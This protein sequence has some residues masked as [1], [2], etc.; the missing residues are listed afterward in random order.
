FLFLRA[1]RIS[2]ERDTI[3]FQLFSVSED[4]QSPCG[5]LHQNPIDRC[6]GG[7]RIPDLVRVNPNAAEQQGDR[8][9]RE[10]NSS[11][12][13]ASIRVDDL[14]FFRLSRILRSADRSRTSFGRRKH[15]QSVRRTARICDRASRAR[16][17]PLA[18][19][20]RG[21]PIYQQ[22]SAARCAARF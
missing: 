16:E 6:S 11:K 12:H 7:Q 4:R 3:T 18:H 13:P 21:G 22:R 20:S 15:C 14:K 9:E 8:D 17:T 5:F 10:K 1:N 2:S 19:A